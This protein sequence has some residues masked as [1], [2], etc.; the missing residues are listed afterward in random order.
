[1]IRKK[2]EA[3]FQYQETSWRFVPFLEHSITMIGRV[4]KMSGLGTNSSE[5]KIIEYA[6]KGFIQLKNN[7]RY[8]QA[9]IAYYLF[10]SFEPPADLYLLHQFSRFRASSPQQGATETTK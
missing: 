9:R 1:M 2:Q 7:S 3:L 5:R 4:A 8:Y 10:T 6:R